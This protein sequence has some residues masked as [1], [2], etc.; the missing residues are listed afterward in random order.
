MSLCVPLAAPLSVSIACARAESEFYDSNSDL[1]SK[2]TLKHAKAFNALESGEFSTSHSI[3]M[4]KSSSAPCTPHSN[5]ITLYH[6]CQSCSNSYVNWF[7]ADYYYRPV[8]LGTLAWDDGEASDDM[9]SGW[10]CWCCWSSWT[11]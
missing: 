5:V 3:R 10:G 7:S 9:A 4:A 11:M 2:M 1:T 6:S 8:D